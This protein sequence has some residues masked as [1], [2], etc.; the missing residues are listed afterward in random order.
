MD[1]RRNAL[2]KTH[3]SAQHASSLLCAFDSVLRLV[4]LNLFTE[5]SRYFHLY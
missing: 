1:L 5:F 4:F 2:F 3:S